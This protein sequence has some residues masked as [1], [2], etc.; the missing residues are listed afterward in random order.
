MAL[1]EAVL[2]EIPDQVVGY[3]ESHNIKPNK[4]MVDIGSFFEKL[5]KVNQ[6][7]VITEEIMT[8]GYAKIMSKVPTKPS[9]ESKSGS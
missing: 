3:M 4:L 8:K 9:T 5:T 6:N 2:K 7:K 1:A